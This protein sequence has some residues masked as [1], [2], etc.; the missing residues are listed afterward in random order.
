MSVTFSAA[1]ASAHVTM[2]Q[3]AGNRHR[4]EIAMPTVEKRGRIKHYSRKSLRCFHNDQ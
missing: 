4:H 1:I 2:K 3:L